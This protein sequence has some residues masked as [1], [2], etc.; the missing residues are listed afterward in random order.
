MHEYNFSTD[1]VIFPLIFLRMWETD[2]SSF[3]A[4][5]QPNFLSRNWASFISIH[6]WREL[7]EK[8]VSVTRDSAYRDFLFPP[9]PHQ[10]R[11]LPIGSLL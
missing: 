9:F 6:Q 4:M 5:S 1:V 11:K 7:T 3:L 10:T 8:I 2:S